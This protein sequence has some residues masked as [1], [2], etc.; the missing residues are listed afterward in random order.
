MTR[1]KIPQLRQLTDIGE[2]ISKG[3]RDSVSDDMK[4]A[5]AESQPTGNILKAFQTGDFSD[6]SMGANPSF[7]GLAGHAANV[8]GTALPAFLVAAVTKNV[9]PA[10]VAGFGQSGSEAIN[11]A[12]E[13]IKKM[14]DEQLTKNSPY[15]ANLIVLGY[16]PKTARQMTEAKAGD[17]AAMYQGVVG[18]LGSALAGASWSRAPL[19]PDVS[20]GADATLLLIGL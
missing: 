1:G 13:H 3:I 8:F 7:M 2:N 14:S 20:T 16:D 11:E 15:F 18:A 4:Q 9:G 10:A 19:T 17:T 12:R 6:I 5:M